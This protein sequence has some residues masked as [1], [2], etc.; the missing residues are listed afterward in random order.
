MQ[1]ERLEGMLSELHAMV[2]QALS[3]HNEGVAGQQQAIIT[4]CSIKNAG[5]KWGSLQPQKEL[6]LRVR[7]Q[8][9]WSGHGYRAA[10]LLQRSSGGEAGV[11][12]LFVAAL[13]MHGGQ[14]E[15][16]FLDLIDYCCPNCRHEM[17]VSSMRKVMAVMQLESCMW[18][19]EL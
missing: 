6:R 3:Q 10:H 2:M 8:V 12:L 16:A 13:E 11:R 9:P 5:Y 18:V 4:G 14:T 15:C 1:R 19:L 7:Q 17:S